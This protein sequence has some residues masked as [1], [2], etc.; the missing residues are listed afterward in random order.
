MVHQRPGRG[1][2]K[3]SP[4]GPRSHHHLPQKARFSPKPLA[5]KR[6]RLSALA[7]LA[8]PFTATVPIPFLVRISAFTAQ[9]KS[10]TLSVA[11]SRLFPYSPTLPSQPSPTTEYARAGRFH[12]RS[13]ARVSS[14]KPTFSALGLRLI[15]CPIQVQLVSEVSRTSLIL[16]SKSAPYL[17]SSPPSPLRQPHVPFLFLL[18]L[19]V[20][21]LLDS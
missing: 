8:L 7:W 12:I 4:A 2:L 11:W 13:R 9:P 17:E 19:R 20:D 15:V 5:P 18:V 3:D 21:S 6:V 14:P 1:S 10:H 16:V